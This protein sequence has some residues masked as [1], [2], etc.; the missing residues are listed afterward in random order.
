MCATCHTLYGN[1]G[2]IGPDLTGGGRANLDYLLENIVDPGAVVS[3]DFRLQVL[4]LKDG[5]VLNGMITAKTERSLTLRTTTEAIAIERTEI[6]EQRE[7]A[8]SLMPEGL[9]SALEEGQA[10]DLIAYLMAPTQIPLPAK[11]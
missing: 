1:G 4:T 11:P 7:I 10:R 6:Q 9:L 3:A 5:R 2:Q 8:Q